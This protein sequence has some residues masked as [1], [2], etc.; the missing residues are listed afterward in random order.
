MENC[1]YHPETPVFSTAA[2]KILKQMGSAIYIYI[3]FS[4]DQDYREAVWT[5]I[6]TRSINNTTDA[7]VKRTRI[8]NNYCPMSSTAR[9]TSYTCSWAVATAPHLHH[10]ASID[11]AL[12]V[13]LEVK[14]AH[15]KDFFW[16]HRSNPGPTL[17]GA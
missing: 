6:P 9:K 17:T 3:Y 13:R 12:Q 10:P 1:R 4:P 11:Y 5:L 14:T 8:D 15:F 2:S 7:R 16:D